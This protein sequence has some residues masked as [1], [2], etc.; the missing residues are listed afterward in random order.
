MSIGFRGIYNTAANFNMSNALRAA[1]VGRLDR[2]R[3]HLREERDEPDQHIES[4]IA[5]KSNKP[6]QYSGAA[7]PRRDDTTC[8]VSNYCSDRE[9][10]HCKCFNCTCNKDGDLPN[11]HGEYCSCPSCRSYNDYA[12]HIANVADPERERSSTGIWIGNELRTSECSSSDATD[13]IEYITGISTG[14]TI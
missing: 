5:S 10:P 12:E 4:S 11:P 13:T 14:V 9:C 2:N 8:P 7:C 1:S 6:S 3:Q